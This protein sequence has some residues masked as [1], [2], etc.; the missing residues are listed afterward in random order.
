MPEWRVN[1]GAAT[2]VSPGYGGSDQARAR[3]P[4]PRSLILPVV[5]LVA[6]YLRWRSRRVIG[7]IR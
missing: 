5:A 7:D 3:R 6:A 2:L 4:P 1:N